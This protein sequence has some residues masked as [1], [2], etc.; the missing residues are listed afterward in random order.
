MKSFTRFGMACGLVFLA[1]LGARP[2]LAQGGK[3]AGSPTDISG[4]WRKIGQEDTHERGSGPDPGEYWG[5]PINDAARMRGDTYNEEW[6]STSYIL[7]CRPHP[8]G[9]QPLGP[10]P[11][12]I[13]QLTTPINRQ[14]IAY[15]ISYDETPGDRM[16]WLDG[17]PGLSPLAVHTW[18]GFSKGHF[19]GDT[20]I[21]EST[22]MKEAF[23]RRN[24]VPSSFRATTIEHISLDEPYLTWVVTTYDDDYLTEP[25]V[26]S[27]TYIR[28]PNVQIPPYPCAAQQE[29]I[30]ADADNYRVPNYFMGE[31]P[32]LTEVAVKYKVPLE[33]VR[34]GAETTYPEWRV[35]GLALKPPTAQFTLKPA[36]TD[37]STKI[38]E[39]ADAMPKRAPTYDKV[40]A[41]HANGNVYM[42]AGAGGN[43][44]ASVGGDG[45]LLVDSG[46]EQAVDKV[47]AAIEDINRELRPPE[48]PDSASPFADTWQATHAFAPTNIRTIINTSPIPDHVGGNAKIRNAPQFHPL[49]VLGEEEQ[50]SEIILAQENASKRIGEM[51]IPDDGVPT[52]TYFSARYNLHRFFNNQAVQVMHMANALT[53]GDSVVLFRKSDVIATGDIYIADQYP[54]IDVDKGGS[55]DGEITALNKVFD[56]CVT[57]FMAQ[58]GTIV[59]PGHGWMGDAADLGYY[60]DMLT[61]IRERIQKMVDGNMTLAQVKAAKP[62]MDY[63]PEY[64][65]EPG[66]TSKFVEAVYRSISAK[67]KGK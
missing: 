19:K 48:R 2:M 41:L 10:D 20:L 34:G 43:I 47:L 46:A 67:K 32:Y 37:A 42:I 5:L 59:I 7:Q 25:V 9:Y 40:E 58:G 64:G 50:G 65:R 62:T 28:A 12:R 22:H 18:E 56:L 54:P 14:L 30:G 36:Y 44:A 31:N 33:G 11:M 24:G 39:R 17:R 13:E 27:V 15:R 1:A 29:E 63:D 35:K 52:N 57:E 55:I 3:G 16:I 38:A 26:R 6:V 51:G 53:D 49:G 60:R 23:H 61:V 4:T 8:T 21:I 45:V 66:V